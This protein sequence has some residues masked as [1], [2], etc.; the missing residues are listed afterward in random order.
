MVNIFL[1]DDHPLII[2]GFKKILQ[3]IPHFNIV[4]AAKSAA[5]TFAQLRAH[6][7]AHLVLL[8]LNLPD[9]DGIAV[10]KRLR[11]EFPGIKIIFLTFTLDGA[12]ILKA[13]QAGANGYV[14]K[15]TEL[16]ELVTAIDT[17]MAGETF[18][19][20]EANAAMITALQAQANEPKQ[21]ASL[22]RRE[23]EILELLVQGFTNQDIAH[24]LSLSTYTVDTHR[25]NML[26][27]FGVHNIQ[28]LLNIVRKRGLLK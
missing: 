20:R 8:D 11:D 12:I 1:V 18:V 26:Q 15:N 22:T 7:A 24:R 16:P 23:K 17:V 6:P 14:L 10:A 9:D 21:E 19:C 13:L 28:G 3:D 4:G 5:E 27:K 25:R 2:E